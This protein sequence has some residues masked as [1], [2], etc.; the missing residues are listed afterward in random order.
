MTSLCYVRQL[1]VL[2]RLLHWSLLCVNSGCGHDDVITLIVPLLLITSVHLLPH[3]RK[4]LGKE[5]FY[6]CVQHGDVRKV[7]GLLKRGADVNWKNIIGWTPLYRV[8][9]HN[10]SDIVKELLK[11]NPKLNEQT[12]NDETALHTACSG[13]LDCVK[14]LLATGQCDLG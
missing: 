9:L 11:Y 7:R 6:A 3:N 10:R 14:L 2:V 13:S 4:Q 8:C 12:N 1:Q 5:L